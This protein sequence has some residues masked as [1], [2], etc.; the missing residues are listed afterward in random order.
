MTTVTLNAGMTLT[1]TAD[2]FASGRVYRLGEPGE[3]VAPESYE[4]TSGRS[5]DIGPFTTNRIY[6]VVS[7][8]GS[9]SY[10]SAVKDRQVLPISVQGNRLGVIGTSL[11]QQNEIGQSTKISHWGRG[12]LSWARFFAKGRFEC[13]I[14]Q[15]MTFTAG[16]EPSGVANAVRGFSG[17][18][19]GVSGQTTAQIL[20][21]KEYLAN[22]V[23]CDIVVIDAGTNDMGS[24]SKEAIHDARVSLANYY[25]ENG[26]RV[27]MLPILSRGVSSWSAGGAER[28]KAAWINQR[29]R[30]LCASTPNCSMF[31]WNGSW[32]NSANA[33]G[34][35]I[36][37]Y[38][39][40]D[41]HFSVPGGVAVG[42]AFATFL[43]R[44]L[45]DPA[46]RVWSQDDKYDA[47]DNPLGN[48]LANPFCTGTSGANGTGSSGSVATGMRVERST[49][50]ATVVCSKETRADN[51]GD[52]QV[53]T[54]TPGSSDSLL[55][56]RT[57]S[58][59]TNHSLAAGSWVQAS[60]EVDIGSFNGWQ[61]VSL[62]LKDN[63]TNGLIAYGMEA[64]DGGSGY[65]KLPT[66]VMNGQIVTPPL[67]LVNGSASVRW[68]LEVRVGSTGGGASGTGVLKAGAVELRPVSDPRKVVNFRG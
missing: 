33:N 15:D 23:S 28:K 27:V 68:R 10:V 9:L 44:L 31:D 8:R 42:E 67:M 62:Y 64:Y 39:S 56:F 49:G 13:P 48:M 24:L 53:M 7:E 46:P 3:S 51:R 60:I 2:A 47:T 34:E 63:G 1:V 16:W 41:I 30:E 19:A 38:S 18:N 59:D 29:T 58:A 35:P 40:D 11:V 6:D 5:I 17:L 55:F 21:R 4:V 12:W 32:V 25:V 52:W 20:A 36:S 26:L 43:T 54:F 66:R 61:G 57:N 65:I 45:P 22:D 50:D 14:W 37:G